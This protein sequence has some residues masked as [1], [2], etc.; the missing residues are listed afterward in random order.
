MNVAKEWQCRKLTDLAEYING[1][2]FKPEDCGEHG[3]P[4]IRIEQLKNPASTTD[5]YSG[6][7]PE[8]HIIDDGDLIFAWSASLFLSIW[9][10][11]KAA[12]NQHLFKVIEKAGVDRH[13]LK[14]VYRILSA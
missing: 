5:Y 1:Y 3:L 4:I 8:H 14:T 10:Q 13:F 12:L 7:L 2:A 9:K 11:G 6:C